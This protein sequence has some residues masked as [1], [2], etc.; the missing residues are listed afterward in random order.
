DSKKASNQKTHQGKLL[1]DATC[2]P[3]NITYPTDVGL[4]NRAREKLENIID[5]LHQPFIGKRKKPRTY[6]E[7][8]RRQYLAI[9]KQRR[10]NKGRIRRAI[11]EQLGYVRRNLSHIE[12]LAETSDLRLLDRLAYKDLLVIQELYR[13]QSIMCKEKTHS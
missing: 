12:K 4:L 13:Q 10:P 9:S 8:A 11:R 3:A 6:R 2:V 7:R 1:V 5:T